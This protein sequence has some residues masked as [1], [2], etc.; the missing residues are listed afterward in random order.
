MPTRAGLMSRL[1]RNRDVI[2]DVVDGTT[3][4]CETTTVRFFHLNATAALVWNACEDSTVDIVAR[5]V[6]AAYPD[7]DDRRLAADVHECVSALQK[8][9][10]LHIDDGPG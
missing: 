9:G 5:Q 4:L 10:L 8:A 1:R 7:E 6:K 3:V 2:W